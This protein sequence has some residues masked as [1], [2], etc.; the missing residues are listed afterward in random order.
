MSHSPADRAPHLGFATQLSPLDAAFLA[1]EDADPHVSLAIGSVAV[2]D[3][4][5]PDQAHVAAAVRSRLRRF[6]RAGQVVRRAP[7]DLAA[8]R[9]VDAGKVDLGYHLRRTALPA[10]GGDAELCALTERVMATRMDRDRPLWEMWV[11]EGLARGRWA[12]LTKLHHSLADGVSGN[13]LHEVL[14]DDP[15]GATVHPLRPQ[16]PPPLWETVTAPLAALVGL[17]RSPLRLARQVASAIGGIATL[18]GSV[19]PAAPS[20]LTGELGSPRRYG[21]ARVSLT[22]IGEIRDV[23]GVTVNDVMLT[24]VSAALR[25]VLRR[26]GEPT[27]PHTVRALVPVS[28]RLPGEHAILDNRVSLVLPFLPVDVADPVGALGAVH[29]RMRT[30]KDSGQAKAGAAV[31]ELAA[32]EPFAPIALALKAAARLPQRSVVTVATNVPGPRGPLAFLGRDLLELLPYVPIAVRLRVGVAALSYQDNLVFGVTTDRASVPE[33]GVL[34]ETIA[35]AAAELL[36][37]ARSRRPNRNGAVPWPTRL[38]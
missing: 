1:L 24:A 25:E 19:W 30:V 20:S 9:W 27:D 10:P 12:V 33:V 16:P 2:F 31:T 3:G 21:V 18:A 4:P 32:H 37:A 29:E 34:T 8:P 5:A 23:F 15:V 26:R 28:V 13:H 6:P 36:A 7:F 17:A 11:V 38:T 14:L 35:R 22:D